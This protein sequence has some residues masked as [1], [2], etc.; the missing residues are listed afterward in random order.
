MY[1]RTAIDAAARQI[2]CLDYAKK[3]LV[4]FSPF[5]LRFFKPCIETA[6]LDPQNATH[7]PDSKLATMI[8]DECVPYPDALAKY[9]AAFFRMSRSSAIR[10]SS[11]LRR[12]FSC[13]SSSRSPDLQPVPLAVLSQVYRLLV[14]IPSRV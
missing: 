1:P 9:A 5:R 6:T 10:F 4:F 3:T 13:L 11:D 2:R 12:A 7:R 8:T 14:V